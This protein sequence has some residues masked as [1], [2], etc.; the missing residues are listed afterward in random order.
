MRQRGVPPIR[1]A[2]AGWSKPPTTA[3]ELAAE[4][5]YDLLFFDLPGTV[6]SAGILR[7]IAQ[8]DY[9]F[10]PVSADKAGIGEHALLP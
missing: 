2:S 4:G 9:I 7:T 10:A 6:N 8:M 3:R 1:C 5:C